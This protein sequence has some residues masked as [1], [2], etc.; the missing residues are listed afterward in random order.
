MAVAVCAKCQSYV[1]VVR[2]K[3]NYKMKGQEHHEKE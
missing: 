1:N 2:P 3:N